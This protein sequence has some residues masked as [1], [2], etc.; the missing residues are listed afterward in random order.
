MRTQRGGFPRPSSMWS[1]GVRS[2]RTIG[3]DLRDSFLDQASP[4]RVSHHLYSCSSTSFVAYLF[5]GQRSSSR[6]SLSPSS[7]L[8]WALVWLLPEVPGRADPQLR[9]AP[10]ASARGSRRMAMAM[11]W[12][13]VG[14][15]CSPFP[16][17]SLH[18][19]QCWVSVCSSSKA[20][21]V[22]TELPA[23]TEGESLRGG[24]PQGHKAGLWVVR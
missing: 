7:S 4:G 15:S 18:A 24:S 9:R 3:S 17:F 2:Q 11:A 5:S 23:I 20:F 1:G 21:F 22:L 8:Y 19:V 10:L 14:V 16:S 12:L 6:L 13:H